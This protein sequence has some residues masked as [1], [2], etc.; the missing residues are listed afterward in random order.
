MGVGNP[1]A[2]IV[3]LVVGMGCTPPYPEPQQPDPTANPPAG[4]QAPPPGPSEAQQFDCALDVAAQDYQAALAGLNSRI[5]WAAKLK[6][7]LEQ[8]RFTPWV[9]IPSVAQDRILARMASVWQESRAKLAIERQMPVSQVQLECLPEH[10]H[11]FEIG[12]PDNQAMLGHAYMLELEAQLELFVSS[13]AA[14]D[15][16]DIRIAVGLRPPDTGPLW[17]ALARAGDQEV[18]VSRR[19][20]QFLALLPKSAIIPSRAPREVPDDPP[21]CKGIYSR[22]KHQRAHDQPQVTMPTLGAS[23]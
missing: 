19:L 1:C 14:A 6:P 18:E 7:L 22:P 23:H 9:E 15:G 20:V 5:E 17:S 3:A 21:S 2:A 12:H 16:R 8:F 4:A 13:A 10:P 11:C